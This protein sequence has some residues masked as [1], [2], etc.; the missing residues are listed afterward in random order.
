MKA[1]G[2][3]ID[4]RNFLPVAR[5]QKNTGQQNSKHEN[6][7]SNLHEASLSVASLTND[8]AKWRRNF[9]SEPQKF[10]IPPQF[11]W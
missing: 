7:C 2:V 11:P 1:S 8:V 10:G 6:Y 4:G 9:G 3:G 5:N